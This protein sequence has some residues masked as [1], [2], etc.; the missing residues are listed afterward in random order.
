MKNKYKKE[1]LENMRM[2]IVCTVMNAKEIELF[3]I[4]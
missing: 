4:W 1:W 3:T 2:Q